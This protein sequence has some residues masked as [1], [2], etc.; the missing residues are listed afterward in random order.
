MFGFYTG[1]VPAV[2]R[3]LLVLAILL[4]PRPSVAAPG[5]TPTCDRALAKEQIDELLV[6]M[7]AIA[8]TGPCTLE[9]LDT[10][11]FRTL[12]EWRRGDEVY[13]VLLG[14]RG[15][16]LDA[17]HEGSALAFHASV[18]L[19]AACPAALAAVR[20]FVGEPEVDLLPVVR[21]QAPDIPEDPEVFDASNP[22]VIAS[23]AWLAALVLGCHIGVHRWRAA[24]SSQRSFAW[25]LAVMSVLALVLRFGVVASL[26]NWYGGFLPTTNGA[27]SQDLGELRFGASSAVLQMLV[28]A[29]APWTAEVAFGLVRFIGALAVPLVMLLV[30]RLGGSI[31]ASVIAGVLLAFAP[32]AVRLSASSSEHVLAG[33]LALGAWAVWLR[34]ASEPSWVPRALAFVLIVLAV[35][36]RV[37]CWPQLSLI[38]LWTLLAKPRGERGERWRPLAQRLLDALGFWV[39]WAALGAY[40][41]F[42][43]VVPSNHP[44]PDPAGVQATIRVL[45][46]QLWVAAS[47]PPHWL[48]P[49]CFALLLSGVLVLAVSRR[50]G[51]LAAA[52]LSLAV[53]FVPLGRNLTH[54]GL[55]GAR[56]F[57]LALPLVVV[58]AG[59]TGD[60]IERAVAK[61]HMD[62]RR[63]A[64]IGGALLLALLEGLAARP[65]WRHEYTFQAEYLY[66]AQEL[67]ALE[68]SRG[69]LD[70]CTLW[71][72]APRQA[73]GEPDLDCC[74][75]PDRSPLTLVAPG[76]HLRPFPNA[77]EPDDREG[78][79]LY[80]Y[81]AVCSVDPELAPR[82]P[83]ALARVRAQCDALRTR[84]GSDVIDRRELTDANLQPRWRSPPLVELFGRG[85]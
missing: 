20:E 75:A 85:L 14:P 36:T 73:T 83:E 1:V 27:A 57:V 61:L 78:C 54:D 28:R 22:L 70:G 21:G 80:Y 5:F 11:M 77:R 68:E 51:V 16:V 71:F 37:D 69:A 25:L 33:T 46:S 48:S 13:E 10:S 53:I 35:L 4:W 84:G 50:L 32:I 66:L 7:R 34:S 43:V 26:G 64:L 45:F 60:A 9:R 44:G 31:S 19:E 18:E 30:R 17:S 72:V 41:W 81:G 23:A 40:A 59:Q 6:R 15:C 8:D 82:A 42:H 24:D 62:R 63:P 12:I 47:E 76:V 29:V 79:H 74:L 65:G 3:V 39:A 58:I 52:L 2:V 56:Y 38:P 49:V 67:T 55:T